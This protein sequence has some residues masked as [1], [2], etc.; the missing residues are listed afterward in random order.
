MDL[1]RTYYSRHKGLLVGVI[2]LGLFSNALKLAIP[3]CVGK[4]YQLAFDG[5]GARSGIFDSIF[6]DINSISSFFFLFFGILIFRFIIQYAEQYLTGSIGEQFNAWLRETLFAKQLRTSYAVFAKRSPGKYLLRYG[7][8]T[9]AVQQLLTKGIIGFTADIAFLIMTLL[10]F[11][12]LSKTL[13][14]VMLIALPIIFLISKLAQRGIRDIAEKRRDL[15]SGNLNFVSERLHA[16]ATIKVMNRSTP[17]INKYNR[18][19]KKLME[20]GRVYQGWYA[21]NQSL[22]PFLLYVLLG[23]VM[24]MSYSLAQQQGET[25]DGSTMLVFI[26]LTIQIIPAYKR[27]LKAGA[28]RQSGFIS[29]AKCTEMMDASEDSSEGYALSVR[30]GDIRIH[31]L[32]FTYGDA[33]VFSNLD[34]HIPAKGITHLTGAQGSGKSTLLKLICGL[35]APEKGEITIDEQAYRSY[36]L[37]QIRKRITLVSNELP[38]LGKTVFEAVSYN[39][40]PDKRQDALKTLAAIG[41]CRSGDTDALDIKIENGGNNLSA[42]QRQLLRIARGLLT[43]KK[44][45]LLDEPFEGL[46]ASAIRVIGYHLTAIS[47]SHTIVIA[48]N[49]IPETLFIQHTISLSK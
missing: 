19:S 31:D 15:R 29:L 25:T 45:I 3:L 22:Y 33:A 28:I 11:S 8:D 32:Q 42:G 34:V 44:V 47:S 48:S 14:L 18:R 17:E 23:V 6:G 43:N 37:F 1:L 10:L 12:L 41:F 39:R 27:L 40:D 36:S 30:R 38:L 35:Y 2:G 20:A 9:S 4:F 46:D 7:G 49:T 5:G 13:T 24:M 26:M 21:L 16:M